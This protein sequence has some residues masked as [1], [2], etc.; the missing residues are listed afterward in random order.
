MAT[1]HPDSD[2]LRQ[3]A[4]WLDEH[5]QHLR[6]VGAFAWMAGNAGQKELSDVVVA[7]GGPVKY[8]SMDCQYPCVELKVLDLTVHFD[9]ERCLAK[10]TVTREVQEFVIGDAA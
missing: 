7:S 2:N 9:R 10:R 3:L 1:K 4:D 8:R 6:N 5:G